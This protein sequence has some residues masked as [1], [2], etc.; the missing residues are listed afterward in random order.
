MLEV[1]DLVCGYPENDFLL[2]EIS[3]T[4]TQG[5]ILGIIGPN[6]SGKTTLLKAIGRVIYP[7]KGQILLR[8]KEIRNFKYKQLARQCAVVSQQTGENA[9]GLTVREYV[10][11]GRIPYRNN[12]RLTETDLDLRTAEAALESADIKSL[13][14]RDINCLS[15]GEKQRAAIARALCQTPALLLL[16]EPT[17]HLDIGHQ[18][19]ILDL[20]KRLNVS[21]LTVI[22]VMHDLNLA[23]L[24]CNRLILMDEGGIR[25]I[26]TPEEIIS[27]D[28]IEKTYKT[29]VEIIKNPVNLK[30]VVTL[31]AGE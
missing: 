15:G 20:L 30:P 12:L 3:F 27:K 10:L 28:V 2:K 5:E 4:V 11:L 7:L 16:D 17:S 19:E 31:V 23:S 29:P 13:A 22:T 9:R 24:Y 18:I 6:G 8:G 14:D 26:G 21:G 1:K 25:A